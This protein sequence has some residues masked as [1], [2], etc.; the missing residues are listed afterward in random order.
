LRRRQPNA[1]LRRMEFGWYH[2]F[3]RQVERQADADAF[4]QAL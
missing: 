3:H 1:T 2:E 4:A